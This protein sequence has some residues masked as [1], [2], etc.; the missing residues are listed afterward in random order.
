MVDGVHYDVLEFQRL[1]LQ[2]SEWLAKLVVVVSVIC[3]R[4]LGL[5]C[6]CRGKSLLSRARVLCWPAPIVDCLKNNDDPAELFQMVLRRQDNRAVTGS[7]SVE[8][9]GAHHRCSTT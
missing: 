9:L 4:S 1:S 5:S 7:Y 2:F 3:A 8:I 6:L